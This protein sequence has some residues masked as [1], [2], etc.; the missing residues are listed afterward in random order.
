MDKHEIADLLDEMGTLLSLKG[1]NLFKIRAYHNA[2]RALENLNEDLET[3]V[4]EK[5]L[6]EI[7]GIGSRLA[8]KITSLVLEGKLA[9]YEKLKK[10]IPKPLLGLLKLPGLGSKKVKIL[11][12]K[13]HIRSMRDLLQACKQGKIAKL[14]GFGEKTQANLLNGISKVKIYGK[15]MLWWNAHL[16]AIPFLQSLSKLKGVTKVE[17]A[18]SFRRC[19]ETVGDFDVLIGSSSP[20]R[21]MKQFLAQSFIKKIQSKGPTKASVRLK[22]DLQV[23]LRVLPK[24]EFGFGLLYFTG[25]KEHNIQLRL[26]AHKLGYTLSEY[27][28]DPIDKKHPKLFCKNK[29]KYPSERDIY[30]ALGLQFIPPELRENMG[31]IQ[32]SEKDELPQLI[33]EKDLRG[34]FHCH[35]TASDGHN[36]LEEMVKAAED[37]DWEYIGISDHSKSSF[38][39]NGLLENSLVKQ[40]ERI[41]FLNLSKKFS[42]HVFSGVE[43]DILKNGLLD[44]PSDLLKELDYVIIS[45]HSSFQL[46]EK[47]QTARMI[48]AIEHPCSTIVGHLTGRLLLEREPYKM[49]VSKVIDACIANGKIIELNAHPMRLDMDWRLWHKAREKGLKTMINP[50][51]HFIEDLVYVE[52]GIK[53]AR[54]GWLRKQDVL[55]TLPLPKLIDFLKKNKQVRR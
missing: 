30:H 41:R 15:R 34:A 18:G 49:N 31:E 7:P 11:Y 35:T 1:E 10:S 21:V 17:I 12:E 13:L 42:P 27:G 22:N 46:D 37:K 19:L 55:N 40:I 20:P 25:S 6:E 36:T 28:L 52:N 54:K 43:C 45:I 5:K 14:P 33:E 47:T 44:F 16:E 29:T 32:S 50:D 4:R 9:S 39:A 23:D 51:A 2:A 24:E 38:Q 48:K 8:K 53:I 26:R 3:L